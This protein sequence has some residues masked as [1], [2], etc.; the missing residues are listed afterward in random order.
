MQAPKF[1][2]KKSGMAQLLL[3]LSKLYQWI[4]NKDKLKKLKVQKRLPK[5]VV[6]VGNINVGGTGKTPVT[7]ALINALKEQGYVVGLISR[8]YGRSSNNVVVS[9]DDVSADLIG[10]EPYLIH[11]KAGV[12]VAVGSSRY[13]AGIALLSEYPEI[14]LIISDDGLQHYALHRDF[15]IA[16]I[17]KQG[18]G[19]GYILPA[20]PLREGVVRLQSVDAV[21]SI[22]SFEFLD[23]LQA[24][25][26][27]IEQALG[28]PYRLNCS[29][30]KKAWDELTRVSAVAGI[31]HPDNFFCALTAKGVKMVKY[32]FSDHHK[33]SDGD[34][35]TMVAPILMTEKDAVKCTEILQNKDVWVVPLETTLP[36]DFIQLLITKIYSK[37]DD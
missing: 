26:F 9:N 23:S 28:K 32:P 34:F 5:P 36:S 25:S 35:A 19:N 37:A 27:L 33:F 1:W 7:I 17:G 24:H 15:E 31:A 22:E 4:A 6:I 13:D 21:L 10:D 18:V 12:P 8:G 3:P 20:G 16:V 30:E 11:K 2:Q 14:D 29:S